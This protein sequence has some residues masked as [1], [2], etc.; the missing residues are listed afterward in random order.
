MWDKF[1]LEKGIPQEFISTTGVQNFFPLLPILFALY[2]DQLEKWIQ[3]AIRE[4]ENE[5]I[6][7]ALT[8]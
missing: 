7:G 4:H 1:K 3:N 8:N 5:L 2:F 6:I